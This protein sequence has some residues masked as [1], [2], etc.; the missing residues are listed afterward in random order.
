MEEEYFLSGYCRCLDSSRMVT[1]ETDGQRIT[2]IDCSY[3]NCPYADNCTIGKQI[4]ELT[5][6]GGS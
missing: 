6:R 1:V 2:D 3:V 5:C 4:G